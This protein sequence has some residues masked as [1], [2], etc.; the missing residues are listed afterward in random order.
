VFKKLNDSAKFYNGQSMWEKRSWAKG[1]P[2][3]AGS[4]YRSSWWLKPSYNP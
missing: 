1:E 4:V 2:Y 3:G